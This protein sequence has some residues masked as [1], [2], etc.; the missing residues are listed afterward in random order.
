M[1]ID[2]PDVILYLASVVVG[3]S[4]NIEPDETYELNVLA[5]RYALL[6]ETFN[7]VEESESNDLLGAM[8]VY[9]V[10]PPVK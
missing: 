1:N 7:L 3:K 5:G 9:L 4:T 6:Y 8:N 2:D 10:D